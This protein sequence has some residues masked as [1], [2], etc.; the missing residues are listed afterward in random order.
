MD[1]YV[2]LVLKIIHAGED[3][4]GGVGLLLVLRQNSEQGAEL[5][6]PLVLG[7]SVSKSRTGEFSF[8][9]IFCSAI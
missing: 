8:S 7:N 5:Q 2:V 4:L 3:P 6:P 9:L 1:L